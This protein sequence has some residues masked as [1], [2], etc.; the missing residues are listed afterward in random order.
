M[1]SPLRPGRAQTGSTPT[2][3]FDCVTLASCAGQLMALEPGD[4]ITTALR[5]GT[6]RADPIAIAHR[7]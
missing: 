6:R 2:M 3:I 7:D 5:R 1:P 4:I